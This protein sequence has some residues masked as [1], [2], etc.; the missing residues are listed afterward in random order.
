VHLLRKILHPTIFP[1]RH[2]AFPPALA[3]PRECHFDDRSA[4]CGRRRPSFDR[5]GSLLDEVI[6]FTTRP[7][8]LSGTI[9]CLRRNMCHSSALW[10]WIPQDSGFWPRLAAHVQGFRLHDHCHYS[11]ASVPAN[12]NL[13]P[14][15]LPTQFRQGHST[16]VQHRSAPA[17]LHSLASLS[18]TTTS[19]RPLH[20]GHDKLPAP[21]MATQP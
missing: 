21:S 2:R 12:C 17:F 13:S 6:S 5:V 8:G 16:H 10:R 9:E 7:L 11:V 18:S 20:P 19:L 4:P 1:R 14:F 15:Q 3:S